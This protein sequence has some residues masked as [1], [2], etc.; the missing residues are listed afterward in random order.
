M[1]NQS[2][3]QIIGQLTLAQADSAGAAP[4]VQAVGVPGEA[5]TPIA[6]TG[7]TGA[8]GTTTPG[9]GPGGAPA[10]GGLSMFLPLILVMVFIMG[11]SMLQSKKERKRR[12]TLLNSISKLDK[13]VVAGGIMGRV[14]ELTETEVVLQLE[15]GKMRVSRSAI[16]QVVASNAKPASIAETKPDGTMANV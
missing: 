5:Q 3:I 14:I 15:D 10:G 8:A 7:S 13:V 4:Q 11:F 9:G 1:T 6:P 16:Q 2:F 12:E